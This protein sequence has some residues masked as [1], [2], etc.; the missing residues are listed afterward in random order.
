MHL[1]Y[2]FGIAVALSISSTT[3]ATSAHS[4]PLFDYEV[5]SLTDEKLS[6]LLQ[7]TT[8]QDDGGTHSNLARLFGFGNSSSPVNAGL[9]KSGACKV[10]PG[11]EAWPSQSVWDGFDHLLGVGSL[12]KT[13]PLA[14]VCYRSMQ[15]VYDAGKC[16]AVQEGFT[17]QYTQYVDQSTSTLNNT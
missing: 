14:A 16:A 2:F 17:N 1:T 7:R 10:F 9:L 15:G 4:H 13:V 3:F 5:N 12:I 6:A 8:T 11:D